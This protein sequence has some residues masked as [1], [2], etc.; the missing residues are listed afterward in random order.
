MEKAMLKVFIFLSAMLVSSASQAATG[1]S[2]SMQVD[3]SAVYAR[4]AEIIFVL[5]MVKL[6]IVPPI[7]P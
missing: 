6:P 4:L 5:E 1:L 7:L 2:I 3:A